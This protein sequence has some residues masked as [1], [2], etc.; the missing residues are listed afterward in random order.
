MHYSPKFEFWTTVECTQSEPLSDK[1]WQ[2]YVRSNLS[3]SKYKA[4]IH[5]SWMQSYAQLRKIGKPHG[6]AEHH[7]FRSYRK[8]L[9]NCE[10][11]QRDATTEKSSWQ[12]SS[13]VN[14]NL[15]VQFSS[16]F[17]RIHTV[18]QQ[19][20]TAKHRSETFPTRPRTSRSWWPM[21]IMAC[22]DGSP[23]CW[24]Q[25]LF[26]MSSLAH[27]ISLH[28]VN[29]RLNLRSHHRRPRPSRIPG[30]HICLRC[31]LGEEQV[32]TNNIDGGSTSNQQFRKVSNDAINIG[33][34]DKSDHNL[35][36]PVSK[37]E[38]TGSGGRYI[39]MAIRGAIAVGHGVKWEEV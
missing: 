14:H 26:E 32:L 31:L 2:N 13:D 8:I 17:Y 20:T 16:L 35:E 12:K 37:C 38:R 39:P 1:L 3:K 25:P 7:T 5:K 9:V 23:V 30:K 6:S 27:A 19:P 28:Y 18:V 33:V 34:A 15:Y 36:S 22:S 24:Q 29:L 10:D 11:E 4:S 21:M